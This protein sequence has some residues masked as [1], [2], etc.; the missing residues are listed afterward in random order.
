MSKKP[1]QVPVCTEQ[2]LIA[3]IRRDIEQVLS[4]VGMMTHSWMMQ[5]LGRRFEPTMYNFCI[6]QLV[7]EKRIEIVS[8]TIHFN[9]QLKPMVFMQW[10]HEATRG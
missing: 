1:L 9:G 8:R 6:K 4:V 7:D 5:H 3:G 10:R 2:D